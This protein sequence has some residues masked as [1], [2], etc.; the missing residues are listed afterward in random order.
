MSQSA[1]AYPSGL[2]VPFRR[3]FGHVPA[4]PTRP[5][6]RVPSAPVVKYVGEAGL[7]LG[8]YWTEPIGNRYVLFMFSGHIGQFLARQ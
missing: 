7:G 2:S 5:I 3:G 4:P 1:L 8:R 6:P